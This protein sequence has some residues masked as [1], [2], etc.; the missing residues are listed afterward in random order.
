MKEWIKCH[1]AKPNIMRYKKEDHIYTET[2]EE[3]LVIF[4]THFKKVYNSDGT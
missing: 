4:S 2:D 1:H 3:K